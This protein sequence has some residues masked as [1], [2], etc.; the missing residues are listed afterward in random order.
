M[1]DLSDRLIHATSG[2][3]DYTVLAGYRNDFVFLRTSH[4]VPP[5]CETVRDAMPAL[6]DLLVSEPE[7]AA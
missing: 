4:C 3:T 7:P 6:F 2:Q 5:G 1:A